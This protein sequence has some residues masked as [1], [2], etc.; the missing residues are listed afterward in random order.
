MI[1]YLN[2]VYLLDEEIRI[3]PYDRGFL[4]ADGAYDVARFYGRDYFMLDEHLERL[5]RSLIELRIKVPDMMKLKEIAYELIEKNGLSGKEASLYIQITR[6]LHYPRQHQF[7]SANIEPT[8]F[9]TITELNLESAEATEG[10]KVVLDN[11]IRW[12]RC[13]IKSISLLPAVLMKQKAMDIGA[14]EA[15]LIRDNLVTEGTH[16]NVI[17]VKDGIVLTP[18][19]SNYILPGITRQVILEICRKIG[20]PCKEI[21]ITAEEIFELHELMIVGTI[22]GIK[23]VIKI[24]NHNVGD[25][26]PG[27]ITRNIQYVFKNLVSNY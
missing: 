6:G 20:I 18:P 11:D 8:I 7:P 9:I 1:G 5:E 3:S 22:S 19:L 14:V 24:D 16:T 10:V 13:D 2:G 17:G 27:N 4:F 25:G 26:F 12:S 23:P 15:I 21:N